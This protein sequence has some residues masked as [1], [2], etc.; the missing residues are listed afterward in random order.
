MRLAVAQILAYD[1]AADHLSIRLASEVAVHSRA[2]GL[3]ECL[4]FFTAF[5]SLQIV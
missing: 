4:A 3:P 1:E 5:L 2:N